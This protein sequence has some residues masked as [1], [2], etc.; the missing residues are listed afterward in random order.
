MAAPTGGEQDLDLADSLMNNDVTVDPH[1]LWFLILQL[2]SM[3]VT[4]KHVTRLFREP[5]EAS[6]H[7]S[8]TPWDMA[9][10]EQ[11]ATVLEYSNKNHNKHNHLSTEWYQIV[12]SI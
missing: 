1:T 8:Y 11:N 9:M 7:T 6:F 3:H 10:E 2:Q 4:R 5:A 12:Y